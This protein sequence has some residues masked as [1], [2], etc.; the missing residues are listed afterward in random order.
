LK[1]WGSC[2]ISNPIASF[3]GSDYFP[4][5]CQKDVKKALYV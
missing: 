3:M 1:E 4:I 2:I 5:C